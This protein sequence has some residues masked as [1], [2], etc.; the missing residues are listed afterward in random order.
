MGSNFAIDL[1]SDELGLDLETA[2][3]YHLQGNHYPPV[4]L[5]MVEPCIE[6]IDAYYEGDYNKMIEMPEGVFYRGQKHAPASAIIEQH[7]L[8]SWLPECD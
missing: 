5:S 6:A 8:D 4:P 7:H 2:I 1:A 3:G